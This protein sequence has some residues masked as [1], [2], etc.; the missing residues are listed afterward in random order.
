MFL[1]QNRNEI[2]PKWGGFANKIHISNG[3]KN[4]V[5]KGVNQRK[6]G[7]FGL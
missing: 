3:I 1:S 4:G 5:Y 7:D 6:R 2:S